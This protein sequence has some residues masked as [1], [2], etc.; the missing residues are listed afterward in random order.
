MKASN[1]FSEIIKFLE[2]SIRIQ[3]FSFLQQE[4]TVNSEC[5]KTA[6]NLKIRKS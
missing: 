6:T 3:L 1:I 5:F 4:V 2:R